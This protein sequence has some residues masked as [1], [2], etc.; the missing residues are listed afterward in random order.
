MYTCCLQNREANKPEIG[1]KM[2]LSKYRMNISFWTKSIPLLVISLLMCSTCYANENIFQQARGFQREGRFDEA[3]SGFKSYLTQS[4][5][6]ENLTDEQVQQYSEA[7][8]QLMNTFQSKGD[9][10]GCISE[11]QEIFKASHILQNQCLRDFN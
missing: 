2:S 10:E 8:M 4:V 3:I 6:E 7:L 5:S 9:P 11:L 1:I